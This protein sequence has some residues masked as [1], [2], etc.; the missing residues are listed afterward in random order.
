MVY[1]HPPTLRIAT[2]PRA[3]PNLPSPMVPVNALRRY[4]CCRGRNY[5]M[6]SQMIR[7][8]ARQLPGLRLGLRGSLSKCMVSF[9]TNLSIPSHEQFIIATLSK[10]SAYLQQSTRR[11]FIIIFPRTQQTTHMSKNR[12]SHEDMPE[13]VRVAPNIEPTRI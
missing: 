13:G 8:A 2:L 1:Q 9:S 12:Q 11:M 7:N 10:P 3:V 5:I 6:L 4:V